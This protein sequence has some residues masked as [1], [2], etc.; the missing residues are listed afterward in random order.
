M[1]PSQGQIK[2][3]RTTEKKIVKRPGVRSEDTRNRD[4]LLLREVL[5]AQEPSRRSSP[6][7]SQFPSIPVPSAAELAA[8]PAGRR[9]AAGRRRFE[10]L[11]RRIAAR[12]ADGWRE[13]RLAI[14]ADLLVSRLRPLGKVW[15]GVRSWCVCVTACGGY[16]ARCDDGTKWNE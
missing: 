4:F 13:R 8:L 9:W 10:N 6:P 11:W 15:C 7:I 3:G 1:D 2:G 12:C 5:P 16:V 14:A